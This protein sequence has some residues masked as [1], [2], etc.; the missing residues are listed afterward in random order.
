M[1]T[2]D[3]S[4]LKRKRYP[5]PIFV[6]DALVASKVKEDYFSAP[7]YQQNDYVGWITRAKQENTRQRRLAQ[8]IDELK[9]GRLYMKMKYSPKEE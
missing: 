1:P 2:T 3:Y 9:D 5:M 7:A 6:M 4:R 8:M